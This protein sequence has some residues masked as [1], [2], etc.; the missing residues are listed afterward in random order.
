M[1][2]T[3]INA[4]NL[5]KPL[6]FHEIFSFREGI[7]ICDVPVTRYVLFAVVKNAHD[8]QSKRNVPVHAVPQTIGIAGPCPFKSRYLLVFK[9]TPICAK[10]P[11]E[12]QKNLLFSSPIN[13][14][15]SKLIL[16]ESEKY[17]LRY[18]L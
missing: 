12:L 11:T 13:G 14:A 4:E 5:V 7:P 17:S 1:E 8:C 18:S 15:K 6:G 10:P 2:V 16:L 9:N 3:I